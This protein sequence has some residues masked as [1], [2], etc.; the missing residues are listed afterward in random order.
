[1]L[2]ANSLAFR[3]TASHCAFA[4]QRI[5]AL[6]PNG[7]PFGHKRPWFEALVRPYPDSGYSPA[8]FMDA[9][10]RSR[11]CAASDLEVVERLTAWLV[12]QP[13][14][15]RLSIN[16][17]P[18]SL[19]DSDFVEEVMRHQS[20][21]AAGG[22]SIC[23]E[24]VEF[25]GYSSQST[26][27]DHAQRLRESGVL[28][29]LDDFGSRLNCFD[30]CAAGIV[31]LLKIDTRVVGGLVNDPNHHAVVRSI[32]A[33]GEG[34]GARVVAEGIETVEQLNVLTATGIEYGQGYYFHKP[35]LVEC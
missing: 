14:F 29:A 7:D 30:L 21:L 28:I 24:L 1:M 6:I 32:Q 34:L 10:Y 19:T 22:H 11:R 8:E 15:T 12:R 31:D 26:L 5:Q 3:A 23:L 18:D 33:L 13:E 25:V 17:H 2:Q 16:I 20:R 9:I 27:V 35:E 4:V